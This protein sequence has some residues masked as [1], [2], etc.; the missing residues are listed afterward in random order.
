MKL[1]KAIKNNIKRIITVL[2]IAMIVVAILL[3]VYTIDNNK[4]K[5]GRV[6]YDDEYSMHVLYLIMDADKVPEDIT[7]DK[8]FDENYSEYPEGILNTS[9]SLIP[10]T[11]KGEYLYADL[12]NFTNKELLKKETDYVF[13]NM[14]P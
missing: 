1:L 10:L 5:K 13:T 3:F 8:T 7:M 9:S 11:K 6:S 12:S 4:F 2:S 14:N